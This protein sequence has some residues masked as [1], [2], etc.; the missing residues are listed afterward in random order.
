[1]HAP[2][3]SYTNPFIV[4]IFKHALFVSAIFWI[5]AIALVLIAAS[6]V[7]KRISLFNL[8][9]AGLSEPRARTYLRF[10]FG[11]IWLVDGILQF[12]PA[13]P[14]GMASGVVQPMAEGTPSWLHSLMLDG[15]GLWNMHPIA[16]A[17]GT[18]WIQIGIA[19]L[20]IV[21]NDKVSR[22]AGGVSATWAGLIWLIGN[23]AGGIFQSSSSILF[24]WPGA[25]LFYVF[26]GAWLCVSNERFKSD[27]SKWTLRILSV[28]AGLG[29]VLQVLP[30]RGFWHGGNENA[31]TA[32]AQDM[33]QTSQPHLVSWFATQIG[34][35]SGT[36]GGGFN[37]LIILWLGVC[38]FGLWKAHQKSWQWPVWAF[39]GGSIFFW[40]SAQDAPFWGGLATD[41]NSLIPMA[42]LT[43]AALPKYENEPALA[44]RLPVEMRNLSGAVVAAFAGA[45]IIFSIGS[46]TW[47]TAVSQPENAIFI[48]VNGPAQEVKTVAPTFTL[49]DQSG[50]AYSLNG[51]KGNYTLLS[52]LDPTCWTDC[53]LLANQLQQVASSLPVKSKLDIVAVV[54]NRYTTDVASMKHFIKT[55]N[56][57]SIK[58]FY[59]VTGSVPALES[60]WNSYGISVSQ[61]KTDKMSAHMNYVFIIDPTGHLRW[62]ISD[63]PPA[64]WAGQ[65]SASYELIRLLHKSGLK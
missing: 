29:A 64:N 13:M 38:A 48:A 63:E 60:V 15:V 17:V 33:T 22:V 24:G 8:S 2:T 54:T 21:S 56:L 51:H 32:M 36:M 6:F 30:S 61:K 18:A 53:A 12:Q 5:I 4:S 27:F 62:V 28:I 40:F 44:R 59:F 23:G 1:M 19:V 26:S 7:T 55:R 14:L 16:L 58:N 31:L 46:M 42:A 3:F 9:E 49:T 52:F 50:Q 25:T 57:A 65:H 34:N 20:L 37:I 39:V 10:I 11:F 45:A 43:W 47:A 35:L 41:W